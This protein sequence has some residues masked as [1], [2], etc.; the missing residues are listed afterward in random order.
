MWTCTWLLMAQPGIEPPSCGLWAAFIPLCH[1]NRRYRLISS[2][3]VYTLH[4]NKQ[5]ATKKTNNSTTAHRNLRVSRLMAQ[6]GVEPPSCGL[7]AASTPL[8]HENRRYSLIPSLIV[9][10]LHSSNLAATKRQITPR[11]RH[12]NLHMAP[13]MAQ[14]GVEPPSCGLWA[15]STPLCHES[16]RYRLI[17]SSYRHLIAV[18]IAI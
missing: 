7:W 1:E 10:T 3:I 8:C 2:L 14:P 11:L 17:S 4:I 12:V 15:A 18:Q 6:P 9:Y 13:L 5:M 16:R